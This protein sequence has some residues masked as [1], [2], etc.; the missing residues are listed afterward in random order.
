MNNSTNA[1]GYIWDFGDGSPQDTAFQPTHTFVNPGVYNVM[2]IALNNIACNVSDTAWVTVTVNPAPPINPVILFNSSGSCDSLIVN[3]SAQ[4]SAGQII[5]WD[6]GDGSPQD[7]NAN[8]SHIFVGAGSYT[9]TLIISDTICI[10]SDTATVII[11]VNPALS[12][13]VNIQ[14][15]DSINCNALN[16]TFTATNVLNATYSWDFGDATSDTINPVQHSYTTPGHCCAADGKHQLRYILHS[17]A[18]LRFTRG[19]LRS[20]N[21][22]RA[23]LLVGLR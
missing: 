17:N 1:Y 23:H 16:A 8:V 12:F 19:K 21:Q 9:V 2:L 13:T 20:D 15:V 5:N 3:F 4:F 6:F 22:F 18:E 10:N 14:H 11:T 7:T